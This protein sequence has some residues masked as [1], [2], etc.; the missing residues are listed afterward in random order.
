LQDFADKIGLDS[1]VMCDSE[2]EGFGFTVQE[3]L[4]LT[5]VN[6]EEYTLC[7]QPWYE[8]LKA[9]HLPNLFKEDPESNNRKQ[10]FFTKNKTHANSDTKLENQDLYLEFQK[11]VN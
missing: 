9:Q 1:I 3:D 7:E 4:N 10:R 11:Y 8:Q 5:A 2:D 6:K